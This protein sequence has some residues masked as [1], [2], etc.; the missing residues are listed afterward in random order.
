[1]FSYYTVRTEENQLRSDLERRSELL[2]ESLSANVEH[3][4]AK[5]SP[6]SLQKIVERFGNREHLAGIAIY[7]VAGQRLA[8]TPDLANLLNDRPP[9]VAKAIVDNR[10]RVM[11]HFTSGFYPYTTRA[12]SSAPWR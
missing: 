3:A 5:G 2:S 7:D 11:R 4:L 8:V 1:M 6:H 12:V 10:V 9:V